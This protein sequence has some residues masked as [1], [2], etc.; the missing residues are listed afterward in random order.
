MK[1]GPLPAISVFNRQRRVRLDRAG[2]E[3]FARRALP[4]CARER[5]AGLTRLSQIDILLISDRRIAQL[6]KRFM[7][8]AGPT[9]VITFQHGE[10]FL[11]VETAQRQAKEQGTTLENEIRLYLV[12]GL[13]HLQGLDDQA[14]KDRR[15]MHAAQ[16]KIVVAAN[17][18]QSRPKAEVMKPPVAAKLPG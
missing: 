3:A 6:H 15:R 1:A 13:L 2:L 4:F 12:H 5:G 7:Q 17:R 8:I 11:S 16:N 14:Q 18:T 9:D 10:I